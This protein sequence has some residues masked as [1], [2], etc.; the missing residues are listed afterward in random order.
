MKTIVNWQKGVLLNCWRN[1]C[2]YFF[3]I[4]TFAP[5]AFVTNQICYDNS[6]GFVNR[7]DLKQTS[8]T[9]SDTR[10][11]ISA[12]SS[13]NVVSVISVLIISTVLHK[14]LYKLYK[15][16]S[17][18]QCQYHLHV[19]IRSLCFILPTIPTR[20]ESELTMFSLC[21][22]T[23]YPRPLVIHSPATRTTYVVDVSRTAIIVFRPDE[24]P[25]FQLSCRHCSVRLT[26]A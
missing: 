11:L 7:L 14:C 16:R 22:V 4:L 10:D 6:E 8:R 21:F 19:L 23:N 2:S 13:N 25:P 18:R 9:R 5:T 20:V 24:W 12:V 17:L 1:V 3:C 26:V 15:S